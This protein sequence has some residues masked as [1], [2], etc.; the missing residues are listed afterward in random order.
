MKPRRMAALGAGLFAL[1]AACS[2]G[3]RDLINWLPV[4]WYVLAIGIVALALTVMAIW[5]WGMS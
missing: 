3:M 2:S 1:W 4:P 5:I